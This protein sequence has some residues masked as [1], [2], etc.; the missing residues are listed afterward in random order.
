MSSGSPIR[1]SRDRAVSDWGREGSG[2]IH[3]GDFVNAVG[4]Q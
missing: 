2:H 3:F 1:V 4:A